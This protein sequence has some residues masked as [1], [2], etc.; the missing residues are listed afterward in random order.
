MAIND[1][2]PFLAVHHDGARTDSSDFTDSSDIWPFATCM[3][4]PDDLYTS[5][6]ALQ[7]DYNN[8][9]YVDLADFAVFQAMFEE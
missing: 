9:E 4:G 3:V 8:D 2:N 5:G 6:C 1:P 7:W